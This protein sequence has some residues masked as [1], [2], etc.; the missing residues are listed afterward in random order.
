M[1]TTKMDHLI[2]TGCPSLLTVTVTAAPTGK[3]ERKDLY[4]Y[5]CIARLLS[6]YKAVDAFEVSIQYSIILCVL[7][8]LIASCI[9]DPAVAVVPPTMHAYYNEPHPPLMDWCSR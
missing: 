9:I 6:A 7:V 1:V 3:S 8:G 5:V 4:T 2:M